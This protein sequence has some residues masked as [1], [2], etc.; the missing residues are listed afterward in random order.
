MVVRARS[1]QRRN[2]R[3]AWAALG[4]SAAC[5]A[6]NGGSAGPTQTTDGGGALLDAGSLA[7]Y[8]AP[9]PFAAATCVVFEGGTSCVASADA[10]DAGALY[11][12]FYPADLASSQPAPIL[13]WGNGTGASPDQYRVLLGHLASWGFAV[14]A[15]TSPNTG[16]GEAMLA[17]EDFLV[18]A[19]T[20][21]GPFMGRLDVSHVGAIGHSQGSDGAAHALLAADAPG[22]SHAFIATL[23]S[24]EP[25]GQQWTCFGSSDP[26]CPAKE[27]FDAMSLG[28]GSVFF[29]DGSKDTFIAPPTQSDGTAGEQ[30]VAAYYAAT[31]AAT[32]R[33]KATLIGAD[34]DD[35]EDTC[36]VGLGCAGVGPNGY[37]GAITAWL[38]AEL[39]RDAAASRAFHGSKPWI[40]ADPAW[41]DQAEADLP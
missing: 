28:S 3:L 21:P 14:V 15:S 35:I 5:A 9:G 33:A 1:P 36:A 7:A 4:V 12:V 23:V 2:A 41:E 11:E 19:A 37:L 17:A 18:A 29:V 26:S 38:R 10:G 6:C 39:A 30:S 8:G 24:I 31:P 25:P 34:H 40:D 32:P 13:T 22:S 27:S 20:A 16:T